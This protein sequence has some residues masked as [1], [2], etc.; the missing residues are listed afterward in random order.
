MPVNGEEKRRIIDL[1]FNQGKTIR[2]VSKIMGKS[3]HD[4]TPV[5][6][7]HRIRLAQNYVLANRE[8]N[9]DADSSVYDSVIPNVKAYKLFDE[10][11]SPLEVTSELNL[12]GPQVQQFYIEYLKLRK[13]H[14]LVITYQQLQDSIE[15]FL[16][17]VRLGKKERLT[18]EQIMNFVKMAD[19]IQDLKEKLQYLRSEVVDIMI[20]KSL[21]EEKLKD[22]HKEREAAQE[23]L[24][25]VNKTLKVKYEEHIR[26]MSTATTTAMSTDAANFS[27]KLFSIISKTDNLK[28]FLAAKDGVRIN[29]A[30]LTHMKLSRKRYYKALKQLRDAGLIKK[31]KGVY[32]HTSFGRIVYQRNIIELI[33]YR[34][35]LKEMQMVDD[36]KDGNLKVTEDNLVSFF[37]KLIGIK[38]NVA[39]PC[40]AATTTAAI[41]TSKKIE[42]VRTYEEMVS[43]LLKCVDLCKDEILIAT[44]VSPEVIINRILQKCKLGIHVKVLADIDLV[45]E[46]FKLHKIDKVDLNSQD[47]N[48]VERINVIGNPWY[49]EKNVNRKICKIPF[50]VIIMDGKEVGIELID[51]T[52]SK[53]FNMG[54]LLRDEN[55]SGV[56]KEYYEK[57]WNDAYSDITK[58]KD[59]LVVKD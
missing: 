3:S 14:K 1:H 45:K 37:E 55:A 22:L 9:E 24:N 59:D 15:Y 7:E 23:K 18:P 29:I 44:R 53:K 54:I 42:I 47:K 16:K 32:S 41:D 39:S 34:K 13:M 28:F 8:Q 33:E 6:K 31:F 38:N 51:Q 11:K 21:G 50:G 58:V 48:A 56:M 36:I 43:L 35:Y 5:T 19:K 20:R 30:T 57:L 2:E 49:P 26:V 46:Y 17:L 40:V 12:P 27:L 25:L 10:G 52:D 4:I